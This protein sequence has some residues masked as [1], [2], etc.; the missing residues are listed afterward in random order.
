MVAS[1]GNTDDVGFLAALIDHISQDYTIDPERVYATGISNGGLMSLRLACELSE[2]IAAV[3]PV[4]AAL[5]EDLYATCTPSYPISVLIINGTEDPL[6]PWDGGEITV[7][8][9][10]RGRVLSTP[11]TVAFWVAQNNCEPTPAISQA[12]DGDPEDGT[13]VRTEV[14]RQCDN[15]AA[16]ALY[17]IAGGGH[18]WPGGRQYLPESIAGKT[19]QEIDANEAICR[20]FESHAKGED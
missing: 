11:D 17:T 15:G 16:V 1:D 18:T 2:K 7:G 10:K 20:F 13:Q 4:T 9:Q 3:A 12:P 19:S 5:S 14:Y 8:R 6:V